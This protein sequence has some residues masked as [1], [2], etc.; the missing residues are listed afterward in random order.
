MGGSQGALGLNRMVRVLLPELLSKGCR[1]VHLTGSNDPDVNSIEHAALMEQPFSDDIPGLL[2]HADLAISRAGAGSLSELAV[3]GT[4]SVL[5]PF[6]QAA[7][8]HQDA[9]AACAAALGAAVIVHQHDP[10]HPT[11]RDTLWRLLGQRLVSNE[12]AD[13]PLPAMQQ[14]MQRLAVRDADQQLA[15]LLQALVP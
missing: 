10:N 7:D 2:Q 8:Q 6:P 9:N 13:N 15:T 14:A 12:A 4:P 5:V 1:V 3:S 11:L